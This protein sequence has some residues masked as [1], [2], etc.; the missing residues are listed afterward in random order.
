MGGL[1][2]RATV[3]KTWREEHNALAVAGGYEL[4]RPGNKASD[5]TLSTFG[6]I[7]AHLDYDVGVL[8]SSEVEQLRTASPQAKAN[9]PIP[10]GWLQFSDKPQ[11]K[12]LN[13]QGLR[14]GFIVFP[15]LKYDQV[16]K[17][18]GYDQIPGLPEAVQSLKDSCDLTI[19][20]SPW[21]WSQEQAFLNSDI[22]APAILLGSGSGPAVLGKVANNGHTVW[23]RPYSMGR[24][25]NAISIPNPQDMEWANGWRIE[26]NIHLEFLV[27]DD[28]VPEDFDTQELLTSGSRQDAL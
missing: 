4:S 26:E 21:G 14:I 13:Q 1:A 10:P 15:R 18:G 3:L 25:L 2:R 22:P 27:L 20:L 5:S 6:W 9:D 11:T 28:T 12:V 16:P 23:M 24:A 7:F 19:G 17:D 8:S